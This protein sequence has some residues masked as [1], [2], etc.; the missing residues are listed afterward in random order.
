MIE[1]A[2]LEYINHAADVNRTECGPTSKLDI[3]EPESSE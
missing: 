2:G 3:Q 1:I